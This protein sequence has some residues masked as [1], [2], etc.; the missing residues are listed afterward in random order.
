MDPNAAVAGLSVAGRPTRRRAIVA[1]PALPSR[2]TVPAFTASPVPCM[3]HAIGVG[4]FRLVDYFAPDEAVLHP[5]GRAFKAALAGINGAPPT[6]PPCCGMLQASLETAVRYAPARKTFGQPV[7]DHQGV[8]LEAGR[9]GDRSRGGAASHLSRGAPDRRAGDAVL[10]ARARSSPPRWRCGVSPTAS[11]RWAPTGCAEHPL[12]ATSPAPR[13]PP[14]DGSIE[15]MNERIGVALPRCS[16]VD[17]DDRLDRRDAPAA[18]RPASSSTAGR[19]PS[20]GPHAARQTT[21][22]QGASTICG[23]ADAGAARSSRHVRRAAGRARSSGGRFRRAVHAQ[24]G[25]TARCAARHGCAGA[26]GG[27]QRTVGGSSRKRSSACNA[28][29]AW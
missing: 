6:S 7:L 29:A 11:R 23:A 27:R 22:G 4:G 26:L 15:M 14:P 17:P 12:A 9:C 16:G 25:A 2:P 1:S 28:R 24:R 13:S 5:P 19:P 18:S 8:R 20:P 21:R 3:V 10:P